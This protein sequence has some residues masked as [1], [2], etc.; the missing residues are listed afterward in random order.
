MTE[1]YRG[2]MAT[3]VCNEFDHRIEHCKHDDI[4]YVN[5]EWMFAEFT[6]E[7]Y[8]ELLERIVVKG[9]SPDDALRFTKED[10]DEK[11]EDAYDCAQD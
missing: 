4:D 9:M 3:L 10:L 5:Q 2:K 11:F 7:I 1:G 8:G 6:A